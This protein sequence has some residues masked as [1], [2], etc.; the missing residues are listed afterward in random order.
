MPINK[1]MRL[2]LPAEAL[3]RY[4]QNQVG[5]YF[6]D[7]ESATIV[8]KYVPVALERLKYS[9]DR[10]CSKYFREDGAS[11]FSHLNND[12]YAMFLYL[13]AHEIARYEGIG[14]IC[15]KLFGLNK[16]LHGLDCYY[17]IDL[18]EVFCFAT[19]SALC[20]AGQSTPIFSWFTRI[21]PWVRMFV[22]TIRC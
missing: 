19:R 16:A 7:G 22:V 20:W 12:Q 18:P 3:A 21:A 15:D 11:T 2:S 6:P 10:V 1:P 4:V 9:L 14:G 17:G 8:E 13:L 5:N